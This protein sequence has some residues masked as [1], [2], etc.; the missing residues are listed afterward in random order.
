MRWPC[1][2]CPWVKRAVWLGGAPNKACR[3]F[4]QSILPSNGCLSPPIGL[5]IRFYLAAR[6][7]RSDGQVDVAMSS[8]LGPIS[9]IT[10]CSVHLLLFFLHGTSGQP[11]PCRCS[12]ETEGK[13]LKQHLGRRCSFSRTV[14][15]T[16]LRPATTHV[17]AGVD[18][19]ICIDASNRRFYQRRRR[20]D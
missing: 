15:R 9:V 12:E 14:C 8:V 5:A 19:F 3:S 16:I 10:L 1:I 20:L 13:R 11:F 17:H 18:T 7:T 4:E 6:R 2:P